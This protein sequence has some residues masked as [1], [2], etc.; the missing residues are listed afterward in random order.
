MVL[1]TDYKEFLNGHASLA[2][3]NTVML[4]N[5]NTVITENDHGTLRLL[6]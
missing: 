2:H 6:V 5:H 3:R 4:F 1:H